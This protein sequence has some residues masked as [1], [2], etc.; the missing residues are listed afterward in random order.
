M[1]QEYT[2]L[3]TNCAKRVSASKEKLTQA[4]CVHKKGEDRLKDKMQAKDKLKEQLGKRIIFIL[5]NVYAK[6][7]L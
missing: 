7:I 1:G 2:E 3:L 6:K 5:K 4:Q